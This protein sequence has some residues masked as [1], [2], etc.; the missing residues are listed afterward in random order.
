MLQ[1]GSQLRSEREF[2]FACELIRNGR[3]GRLHTITVACPGGQKIGRPPTMPVPKGFDYD[4]WLGPAPKKPYTKQRCEQ[5]WFFFISDYAP[6]GFVCAWGV[7]HLDVAQW[8]NG[9]DDTYPVEIE[10]RGTFP[11]KGDLAE[12]IQ[13]L[14]ISPLKALGNDIHKNLLEPLA[15]IRRRTRKRNVPEIRVAVRTG[16][17]TNFDFGETQVV[18]PRS[19]DDRQPD[20]DRVTGQGHV[21]ADRE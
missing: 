4:R 6:S 18:D 10:G 16:D 19:T 8:G 20:H 1:V 17:T 3:I 9:T 13:V 5:P 21:D 2:R 7:H 11:E 14:Y 15:G 12:G